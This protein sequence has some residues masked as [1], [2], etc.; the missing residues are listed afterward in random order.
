MSK[1]RDIIAGI[2]VG[3][4]LNTRDLIYI[5]QS[6]GEPLSKLEIWLPLDLGSIIRTSL[7]CCPEGHIEIMDKIVDF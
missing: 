5:I 1:G 4:N 3:G 6:L 2:K 7:L